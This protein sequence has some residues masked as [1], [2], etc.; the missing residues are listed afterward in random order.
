VDAP[1]HK[2]LVQ[3]E[4][5]RTFGRPLLLQCTAGEPITHATRTAKADTLKPLIERAME[6]FDGEL[7][8]RAP[9]GGERN[10]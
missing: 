7:I 9:R 8:D 6:V 10:S 5:A 3:E 2:S 1:E 4:L